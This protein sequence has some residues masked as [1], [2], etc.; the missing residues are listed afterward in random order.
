MA[1]LFAYTD[2]ACSGNPGPGGWGVLLRAMDGETIVKE[3]ELSGGEA[4]T[5][6][7]RME[8]LA[9]INALESLARP[10][11][12]TVVTDSA[13]VKNGVTGWIHG[14]KR[15]GWKT[16]SKKPVK[17]VELWQRLDEAQRRHTVTWEWVKGHAG[18]PENERAD[19]LARAGMAPFKPGKA[20]A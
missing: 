14:W 2:G 9:A 16:A 5:T 4:E 8:L 6:N 13:Y 20:K 10:S 1:E 15:N 18:N 19:E 3:K 12:L 17:N 11:T 7:N